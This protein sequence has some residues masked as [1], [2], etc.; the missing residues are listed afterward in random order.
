MGKDR[1]RD[2]GGLP[3]RGVSFKRQIDFLAGVPL[4][5]A[6]SKITRRRPGRNIR[7]ILVIKLAAMGDTVL[8]VPVLRSMRRARPGVEIH[9]LVSPINEE[10]ARTVPFV[11]RW[12]TLPWR[13]LRRVTGIVRALRNEQFD[14][15]VDFE[16][17]ARLTGLIAWAT[18]APQRCGFDTEGQQR[19]R[20][21]TSTFRK[22]RRRHELDNFF[23][24]ASMAFPLEADGRL[25][26]W[27][28]EGGR[29]DLA[30][31]FPALCQ[32]PT[33]LRALLHPGCGADGRPREW[34]V[35]RYAALG[36][37]LQADYGAELWIS[38]G[39]EERPKT[40]A[41]QRMIGPGSID[42][43]GQLSWQATVSLAK[44][45]DL[46]VSGNTGMMH[47]A[48][49]LGRPQ[50][51]L[52]GPTDPQQWGPLNTQAKVIQSS[53]P[54]CPCLSLGFEYH[55]RDGSCMEGIS[56][57]QVQRAVSSLLSNRMS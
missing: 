34:P 30:R 29:A 25:E 50:V 9:W 24:L 37:W 56:I 27:E 33:A 41:L 57:D 43:G 1:R 51:A 44:R 49:A 28:T 11:D 20:L 26:L 7:K 12:W 45:M 55:R 16:Q 13:S 54:Q 14:L 4:A 22:D 47:I 15:V 38:G 5:W 46:V 35:D 19:H 53:C 17:W 42:V 39:P 10:L 36:R 32:P 40:Q 8:L 2:V 18:G 48:A 23:G 52:H 21:Y 31:R 6:L 3:E